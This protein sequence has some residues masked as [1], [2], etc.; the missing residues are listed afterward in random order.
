MLSGRG[1]VQTYAEVPTAQQIRYD[2]FRT[3]VQG[4]VGEG[5]WVAAQCEMLVNGAVAPV[6]FTFGPSATTPRMWRVT[7]VVLG[8]TCLTAPGPA[9]FGN[10]GAA[11]ANGIVFQISRTTP[12]ETTG[13]HTI[14]VNPDFMKLGNLSMN[15]DG[16][17]AYLVGT[18]EMRVLLDNVTGDTLD[19]TVQ[20]NLTAFGGVTMW[21]YAQAH[22]ER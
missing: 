21:A 19:L 16:V 2:Y 15:D 4:G 10:V 6:T 14:T 7:R 13:L 8:L 5:A 3:V 11:L 18:A 12:A 17:N 22:V 9:E 20:D 1:N